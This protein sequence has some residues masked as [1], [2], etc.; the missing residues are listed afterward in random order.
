MALRLISPFASPSTGT[1]SLSV[2]VKKKKKKK[3]IVTSL[4]NPHH[5]AFYRIALLALCVTLLLLVIAF[6]H[7][8]APVLLVDIG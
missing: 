8:L 7:D 2:F 3:K 5:S 6:G 1:P 4:T